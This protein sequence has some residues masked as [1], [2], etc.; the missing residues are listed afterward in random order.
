MSYFQ[1]FYKLIYIWLSNNFRI[2]INLILFMP[3]I[4]KFW[5]IRKNIYIFDE[6]KF[7]IG[8]SIIVAQIMTLKEIKNRKI[9][10]SN[11]E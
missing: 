6:K 11:L 4:K 2:K 5:V 10:R 1:L 8:V 7:M 3:A 9:I